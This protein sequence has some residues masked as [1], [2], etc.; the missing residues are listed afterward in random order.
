MI[1]TYSYDRRPLYHGTSKDFEKPK[2]NS[3]GI[4]WLAPNAR[5]AQEYA[6][7]R[8]NR[9]GFVWEILLKPSAK[10]VD[11][12][13]LHNPVIREL[14]ES[15]SDTRRSTFGPISEDD[16]PSFASFGI[17]EGYPWTVKFL[18]SKKIDG[19]TCRDAIRTMGIPHD[20]VALINLRAIQSSTR[21]VVDINPGMT[22]GDIER[23]VNEWK[24]QGR[25]AF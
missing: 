20:S 25:G 12:H 5:V 13:D 6:A 8:G 23:E 21:V 3:L 2:K 10:I 4:L 11:L 7:K 14:F 17:F 24:R 15:V 22:I 16:W 1:A 19:A 18:A 9:S